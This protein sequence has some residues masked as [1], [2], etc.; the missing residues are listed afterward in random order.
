MLALM[1]CAG[2]RCIECSRLDWVDVDLSAST[3]IVLGKGSRER[4]ISVSG[5]VTA[6]LA[7]LALAS[8]GRPTGPVFVGPTG[9]RMSP[10]RVSQRVARAAAAQGLTV[11][12]HQLRH[13]CATQALAQPGVDLLEVRDLLGHASV[14]TTQGYTAVLPERTAKASRALRLPAA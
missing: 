12:A 10:A 2:L 13:R 14:S 3:V 11:R 7:A 8:A 1:A 5:D 6:S 4:L 9:R